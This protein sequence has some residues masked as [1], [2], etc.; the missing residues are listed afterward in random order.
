MQSL[1]KTRVYV[2]HGKGEHFE[3]ADRMSKY[4]DY[5]PLPH[6]TNGKLGGASHDDYSN[7]GNV[8]TLQTQ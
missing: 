7:P 2:L 6:T 5:Q 1:P 3:E 8:V 4:Y